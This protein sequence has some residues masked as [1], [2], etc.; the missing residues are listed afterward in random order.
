MGIALGDM[1]CR[2]PN[3]LDPHLPN[4]YDLLKSDQ[5]EVKKITLMVLTHLILNDMIKIKDF[6][7]DIVV[8]IEDGQEEIKR[9]ARFFFGELSKKSKNHIYN[10]LP[11]IISRLCSEHSQDIEYDTFKKLMKY[12]FGFIEHNKQM[13]NLVEKLLKRLDSAKKEHW[14]RLT[15]CL[16]EIKWQKSFKI[17]RKL[18]DTELRKLYLGKLGEEAVWEPFKSIMTECEKCKKGNDDKNKF[19]EWKRLVEENRKKGMEDV[20]A[21]Q[22]AEQ[23]NKKGK[24]R[25]RMEDVLKDLQGSKKQKLDEENPEN[26]EENPNSE[27]PP[28]LEAHVPEKKKK[29]A[30]PKKKK[31]KKGPQKKKKKKKK[32]K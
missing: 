32:K 24:K 15:Y 13:E 18:L 17:V 2:F 29:G 3:E 27:G 14:G 6:I 5:N 22:R 16:S 12:M 8:L 19:E 31:K 28:D 20:A 11:D 25:K 7:S 23:A 26:E 4:L 9:H 30:Q 1:C 10:I 21:Q